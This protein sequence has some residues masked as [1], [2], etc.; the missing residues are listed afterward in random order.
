[1]QRLLYTKKLFIKTG[2]YS[3]NEYIWHIEQSGNSD[4]NLVHSN[5]LM[6][7]VK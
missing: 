5:F 4:H 1:M 7:Y 2:V 3:V 6:G